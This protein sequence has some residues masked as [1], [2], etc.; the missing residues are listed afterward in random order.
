M[1]SST[2]M[3]GGAVTYVY[4]LLNITSIDAYLVGKNTGSVPILARSNFATI[5]NPTWSST[6]CFYL[7]D[8]STT[9]TLMMFV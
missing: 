6:C 5:K 2:T 1:S 9:A 7:V 3:P 8:N 4:M